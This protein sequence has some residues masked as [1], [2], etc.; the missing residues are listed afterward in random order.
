MAT[1]YHDLVGKHFT[2]WLVLR[3]VRSEY[4][5]GKNVIPVWLCRCD[6]GK[7]VEV[8]G[9]SLKTGKSRSCGC[10]ARGLV[11]ATRVDLTGKTFGRWTVLEHCRSEGKR[12]FYR[13]RCECG[14]EKE[15]NAAYLRIGD[16]RSCGCLRDELTG[17]RRRKHAQTGNA[18]YRCWQ[19]MLNRCR[20]RKLPNTQNYSGR[21]ITVC[22]R[23]EQYE[24]FL[25]DMGPK[26]GP[27][28]SLERINNSGNYVPGNVKWATRKEQNRNKRTNRLLTFNGKTL[29]LEAWAEEIK[30]Q[31]RTLW[32]RLRRGWTVERTLTTF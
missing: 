10:L 5:S 22:K 21:G 28:Y 7:E 20:N 31:S 26:P 29:C 15:V 11:M 1:R 6:C 14:T 8:W 2:R 4:A 3:Y 27:G 16:S 30:V 17:N 13:C 23:W 32:Q 19:N 24:G 18:T 25:A 12:H 9:S